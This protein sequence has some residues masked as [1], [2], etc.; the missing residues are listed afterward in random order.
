MGKM[1]LAFKIIGSI[2]I[3]GTF[4]CGMT[5]L[6]SLED[7]LR[8]ASPIPHTVV[9]DSE[10]YGVQF[11][12]WCNDDEPCTLTVSAVVPVLDAKGGSTIAYM[13]EAI[14]FKRGTLTS[15]LE[16]ASIIWTQDPGGEYLLASYEWERRAIIIHYPL[17]SD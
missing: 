13:G 8:E 2:F 16:D 3:A 9:I 11:R 6:S 1:S 15:D 17:T 12:N 4:L 7:P 14:E 10:N 5:L